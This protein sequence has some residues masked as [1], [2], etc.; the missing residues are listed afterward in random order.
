MMWRAIRARVLFYA[1]A[2]I[3]GTALFV[4]LAYWLGWWRMIFPQ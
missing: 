3:G 2:Y 1:A 4:A